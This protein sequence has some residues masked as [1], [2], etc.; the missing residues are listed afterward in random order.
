MNTKPRRWT[1]GPRGGRSFMSTEC[2]ECV[3]FRTCRPGA[4]SAPF[5][6]ES[7][8]DDDGRRALPDVV[9]DGREDRVEEVDRLDIEPEGP[10]PSFVGVVG[11]DPEAGGLELVAFVDP[12]AAFVPEALGDGQGVLPM[13]DAGPLFAGL[14]RG[15]P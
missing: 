10:E 4:C 3:A 5:G 6:C 14:K 7:W 8:V 1:V 12:P 15:R 13:P 2:A 11:V 9:D